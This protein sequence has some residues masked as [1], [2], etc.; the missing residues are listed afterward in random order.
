MFSRILVAVD[1]SK[2][3]ER[4]LDFATDLAKKYAAKLI[5]IHVILNRVYA[6]TPSEAG[7]MAPTVCLSEKE[8]EGRK[9]IDR[10]EEHAGSKSVDFECKM[11]HGV[12]ADEIVK[13]V[14]AERV[15]LVVLGSRG[16]TEVRS[17]LFGSVSDR[18]AHRVRCPTL[19][20]K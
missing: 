14:N 20:V 10:A 18:V 15:D 9:I 3:A 5:I 6:V 2:A 12:P 16:L 13:C 8:S 1:G 17:F 7:M 4:A 19:I 11:S